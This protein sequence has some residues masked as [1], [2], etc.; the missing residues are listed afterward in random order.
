VHGTRSR[1]IHHRLDSLRAELR[2]LPVIDD[3]AADEV[4]GYDEDGLPT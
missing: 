4:L 2:Q 3:R 1:R